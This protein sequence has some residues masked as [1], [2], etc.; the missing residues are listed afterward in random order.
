M[1]SDTQFSSIEEVLW[2]EQWEWYRSWLLIQVE[3]RDWPT[4]VKSWDRSTQAEG[5]YWPTWVKSWDI[6]VR[7]EA[8]DEHASSKVWD[9]PKVEMSRPKPKVEASQLGW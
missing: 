4:L 5:W 8:R 7:V 3:G 2:W 6:L 9:G 1:V